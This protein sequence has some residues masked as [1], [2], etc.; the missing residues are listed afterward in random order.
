M[1]SENLIEIKNN[2]YFI[3]DLMY[4]SKENMTLC[5]VYERI[6]FGNKAFVRHELYEKL[7]KLFP[8]L[9]ENKLKL[10]I[11]DAYRPPIA[12]EMLHDIVP[13]SGFFAAN[14]ERSLH[15]RAAAIDC[16]LCLE[17][18][19]ELVYP[20]KVD[21]YEKRFAKLILQGDETS[22]IEH[23][24]MARHD[25]QNPLMKNE[26]SNREKLKE[27]MESIGLEAITHEWWHY[28]LPNGKQYPVVNW[29]NE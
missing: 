24:K 17:D 23:L 8:F 26:I 3:V 18:G 14:S 15:C 27:L 1:F 21:A 16:C 6:G 9:K 19:S 29:K 20:T 12:H 13:I 2:D 22:F 11:C 28:N 7:E 5:P 4:A 25:Y 10:K